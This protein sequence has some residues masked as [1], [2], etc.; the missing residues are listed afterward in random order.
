MTCPLG[1]DVWGTDPTVNELQSYMASFFGKEKAIIFP[2]GTQSN[3]TA[4]LTHVRN[5]GDS[6]IMGNK[7]HIYKYERGGSAALGGVFPHVIPNN[8]DGTFD[9][10]VLKGM[11]PPFSEHLPQPRVICLENS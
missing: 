9:L 10:E 3:L 5:K 4:M 6:A 11:I 1:D 8:P 2:S 7:C